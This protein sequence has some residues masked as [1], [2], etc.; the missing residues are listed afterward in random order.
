MQNP[1]QELL[2]HF[3]KKP[4]TDPRLDVTFQEA[5]ASIPPDQRLVSE[6]Q[7]LSMFRMGYNKGL[8][9]QAERNPHLIRERTARVITNNLCPEC[10]K[11][12]QAQQ[13][14]QQHP[15]PYQSYPEYAAQQRA[16]QH[17]LNQHSEH[18]LRKTIL[19][20]G[21][22]SEVPT[23]KINDLSQQRTIQEIPS[24]SPAPHKVQELPRI[25]AMQEPE[26]EDASWLNS[27]PVIDTENETETGLPALVAHL[28]HVSKRTA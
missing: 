5:L 23:D 4:T 18:M 13:E 7:M 3:H 16:T 6:Q 1:L 15:N 2:N 26:I 21:D 22:V 28:K 17:A 20:K 10:A 25:L 11:H 8:Q 24:M 9:V 12:H 19:R 27:T 14:E